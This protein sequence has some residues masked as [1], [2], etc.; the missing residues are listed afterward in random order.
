[1]WNII[2]ITEFKNKKETSLFE[3]FI[4]TSLKSITNVIRKLINNEK[5]NI[6][7]KEYQVAIID[8]SIYSGH[9]QL[10]EYEAIFKRRSIRFLEIIKNKS[11]IL[12]IRFERI[13]IEKDSI[14][15]ETII[16]FI[17]TIKQINP[18]ISCKFLLLQ[19]VDDINNFVS[20]THEYIIHKTIDKKISDTYVQS[21]QINIVFKEILSNIGVDL[22]DVS[23]KVLTD[24]E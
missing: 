11:E 1:M 23:D 5:I 15:V 10:A 2:I 14:D 19:E 8:Y 13:K 16:D 12:F 21:N 9:Y 22:T 24:K 18:T 3:W 6:I 20:L 17:E 7:N 4:S